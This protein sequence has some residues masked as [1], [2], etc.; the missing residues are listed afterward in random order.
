MED[1]KLNTMYMYVSSICQ[2]ESHRFIARL[3]HYS[4]T[5]ISSVIVSLMMSQ[6]H[7]T[8]LIVALP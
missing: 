3:L 4:T 2:A 1:S 5:H 7:S 6:F 8:S